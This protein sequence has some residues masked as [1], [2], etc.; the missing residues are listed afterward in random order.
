M[1]LLARPFSV[2]CSGAAVLSLALAAS[3]SAY[4]PIATANLVTNTKNG[5][6]EMP[7]LDKKGQVIVFVSNSDHTSGVSTPTSGAF[8]YNDTG[9]AYADGPSP[10]PLCINCTSADDNVGNLY[11]WRL[12]KKGDHPANAVKQLTFS[13]S[14][15]FDANE[16][17]DIDSKGQWIVWNSEWD[18]VP[19]GNIDG[20]SEIFMMEVSTGVITQITTTTGGGGNA[21]TTATVSDKGRFVSFS[22]TRD[23][24][25]AG[26]CKRPDGSTACSNPDNNNEVMVYDRETGALTQITDTTGDGND[27]QSYPRVSSDGNYV[28][29]TSTRDFSGPLTGGFVCTGLGGAGCSN[30]SNGEIM[31]FDRDELVLTQVTNTIDQAGCN[32]KT[33]NE[34]PEISKK[35]KYIV[36]QSECED[37]LNPGGC[38]DCNNNDEVFL[39]GSKKEEITQVTISDGGWNRVPRISSSGKYFVFDSNRSYFGLNASHNEKLYIMKRGST[40]VRPG[41]T[42][43][44][45]VEEDATL[46]GGGTAQNPKTQAT[47]I[48]FH[49]GFPGSERIGMSGNGRFVGFESSKDVGNQE[50]WRIDRNKCTHGFPDCL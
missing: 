1:S 17:P 40:K 12:K 32:D 41:I 43:Q 31:V 22:S 14:G 36:F 16:H 38:G 10:S 44:M 49:G 28:A 34:R 48:Q 15:G 23:F 3:A 19:P 50:I 25:G 8:D 42:G 5:R 39:F 26:N 33:S 21:N 46:T 47:T 9:N 13:T 37:Q 7:A 18:H 4:E 2:L 29:F 27:A 30:D 6:N 24:A 35:G 11:L 20:N 45:Q